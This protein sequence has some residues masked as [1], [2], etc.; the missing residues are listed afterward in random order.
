MQQQFQEAIRNGAQLEAELDRA[1]RQLAAAEAD[2]ASGDLYSWAINT[3]RQFKLP[4]KVEMPQF[5]TIDG[6]KDFFMLPEFPYK[7]ATLTVAGTAHFHDFGRFLADFENHFSH[8]CVLNLG[9]DLNPSP[10]AGDQETLSF[11]M[12]IV[13]LVKPNPS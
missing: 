12:D 4:Y 11:K 1:T 9:L 10:A 6:P 5:S 2:M 13:T 7:Q 3:I 8:I